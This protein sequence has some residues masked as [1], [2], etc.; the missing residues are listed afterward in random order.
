M[1]RIGLLGADAL[2]EKHLKILQLIPGVE[3][4]GIYDPDE[5]VATSFCKRE[6]LTHFESWQHLINNSDAIDII[7]PH[8]SHT[9]FASLAIKNS[10]HVFL[11]QPLG[12][13]PQEIVSLIELTQEADVCVQPGFIQRFNPTFKAAKP[14][15]I[16]PQYIEVQSTFSDKGSITEEDL[17]TNYLLDEIDLVNN[18]VHANIKKVSATCVHAYGISPNMIN[19]RL[20]F[21]NG[22]VANLTIRKITHKKEHKLFVYQ[23]DRQILIDLQNQKIFHEQFGVKG[24]G[25]PGSLIKPD[26][27]LNQPVAESLQSFISA[28]QYQTE[29]VITLSDAYHTIKTGQMVRQKL[30]RVHSNT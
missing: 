5:S 8:L 10:K 11:E 23:S 2:A 12:S 27:I 4:A 20:E 24:T 17:L 25:Q 26:N 28:I 15:I 16:N 13:R 30:Q 22:A 14:Y 21:D 29:P 3:I 9:Y 1:I 19:S 7:S 18:M 6:K